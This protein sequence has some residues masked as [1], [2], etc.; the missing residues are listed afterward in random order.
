MDDVEQEQETFSHHASAQSVTIIYED[1]SADE[2]GEI[3][4]SDGSSTPNSTN[5]DH[6]NS[7]VLRVASDDGGKRSTVEKV[8]ARTGD[9]LFSINGDDAK[10]AEHQLLKIKRQH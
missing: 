8:A 2:A 3:E 4:N 1:I 7:N 9:S 10:R 6:N 5:S